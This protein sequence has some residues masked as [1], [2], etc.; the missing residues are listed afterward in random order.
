MTDNSISYTNIT[1]VTEER[2]AV[3]DGLLTNANIAIPM[4][5][6]YIRKVQGW[7]FHQLENRFMGISKSTF[8]CYFQPSYQKIRPLHIIAAYSWFTMMPM[9]CLYYG[10]KIKEAY[11]NMDDTS[12]ECLIHSGLLPTNQFKLVISHL[13]GYLRTE[14][15]R[16][17]DIKISEITKE[18]GALENYND[19]S[20]LFPKELD[21]KKFGT[22]YYR[23]LAIG[24]RKIRQQNNLSANTMAKIV[25]LSTYRYQRLE[26]PEKPTPLPV[27]LG[28]KLQM[29]LGLEN[30]MHFT[31]NMETYPQ[32][33]TVRKL[34]IIRQKTLI[35]LMKHLDDKNKKFFSS[36]V[37]NL[38]SMYLSTP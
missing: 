4:S 22:D 27:E 24:C 14:D 15:Q 19:N 36:M 9:A 2:L 18:Y 8:Q 30:A 20:F 5:M 28:A 16:K 25:G 38:S 23:S 1:P 29:G 26:D 7:D 32:F 33:H 13:H 3:I 35:E 6:A 12:T 17:A 11:P 10:L 34:Q 37:L 21:I 31:A